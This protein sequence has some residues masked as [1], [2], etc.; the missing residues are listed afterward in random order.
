MPENT[1]NIESLTVSDVDKKTIPDLT[2]TF[3]DIDDVYGYRSCAV[4]SYI[5]HNASKSKDN[6]F[7]ISDVSLNIRLP[8][9]SL[10]L[11]LIKMEMKGLI[12]IKY[13]LGK[14]NVYGVT[15]QGVETYL[16]AMSAFFKIANDASLPQQL[17]PKD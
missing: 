13:K 16:S 17:F 8:P 5:Y 11:I 10:R 14:S 1:V 12:K 9:A 6:S 2:K 7:T 3:Y 4:L 15:N